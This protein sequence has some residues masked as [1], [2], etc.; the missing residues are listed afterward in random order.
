[1]IR[2]PANGVQRRFNELCQG[3][4][5]GWPDRAEVQALL[6]DAG[7]QL[8]EVGRGEI[9]GFLDE[10]SDRNPWHVCFAVGICWG[11]LA[12]LNSDFIDAAT[13]LLEDWNDEDLIVAKKFYY[14]RGPDPI[15]QSLRGGHTVFSTVKLPDSIPDSLNG[16][17]KV[18]G[19]WLG[20]IVAT[21][22][23][24]YMGAW[25]GTALFMVALFAKPSIAADLIEPVIIL[26]PGGPIHGAL[27]ILHDARLISRPPS[28]GPLDD[29]GFEP[30]VL[31]EN[32]SLFEEIHEGHDGWNFLDVHSG[33]YMLGT[34]LPESESWFQ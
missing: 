17:C 26:P 11:R 29:D 4:R 20:R 13:Q 1:M 3:G 31:W 12:K 2:N 18:Q 28:G 25:N 22:R 8:N 16:M 7:D 5:A 32:N 33:L 30:G 34:K 19:R 10:F 27:S 9:D 24:P 14:E 6:H 21:D 23:P 15:E